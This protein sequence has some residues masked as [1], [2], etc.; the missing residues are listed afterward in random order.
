MS[1]YVEPEYWAEGYAVGDAKLV[2][3]ASSSAS[4]AAVAMGN[5]AYSGAF[6]SELTATKAGVTR[7][8]AS[9]GFLSNAVYAADGYWVDGYVDTDPTSTG[10][11][12]TVFLSSRAGKIIADSAAE[13]AAGRRLFNALKSDS[14]SAGLAAVRLKWELEAEPTDAWADVTETTS[15]WVSATEVSSSWTE[16]LM[17][18]ERND[19]GLD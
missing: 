2:A 15:I 1:Y 9:V 11:S 12:P 5:D 13:V 3:M 16:V 10:A 4:A 8:L 19:E 17:P 14:S 7:K 18:H 6:I